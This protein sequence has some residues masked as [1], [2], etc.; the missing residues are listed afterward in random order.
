MALK[1]P[2]LFAK[3]PD[4]DASTA[5]ARWPSDIN[6]LPLFLTQSE[7]AHLL[8]RSVRTL[9]RDRATGGRIPF[10]KIGRHIL[11]A[12][13]DV[14]SYLEAA[15]RMARGRVK[16]RCSL[17]SASPRATNFRYWNTVSAV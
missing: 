13:R 5:T 15:P 12:R 8:G 2:R 3:T 17:A 16:P 4:L 7:L 6:Q 10:K 1:F 9:E 14:L 11:Y